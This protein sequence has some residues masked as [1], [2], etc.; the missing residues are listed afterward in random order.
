MI[1][2]SINEIEEAILQSLDRALDAGD[3]GDLPWQTLVEL[4]TFDASMADDG[5][6]FVTSALVAERLGAVLAGLP[7]I[8]HIVA[9]RVLERAGGEAATQRAQ[10]ASEH[11]LVGILAAPEQIA[12]DPEPLSLSG[13]ISAY[14][15]ALNDDGIVL[16]RNVPGESLTNL[17]DLPL[18]AGLT[19]ERIL[20]VSDPVIATEARAERKIL[21]A[22]A[23]AGM[24]LK[25]VELAADYAKERTLFGAPIGG[26]QSLAHGMASGRVHADGMLLLAREAAWARDGDPDR[27]DRLAAMAYGFAAPAAGEATRFA[28]HVFGGYGVTLEYPVQAYFRI[29]KALALAIGDPALD[30][31]RIGQFV[32][33]Q[34]AA[35]SPVRVEI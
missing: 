13:A 11:A 30:L 34:G 21:V 8:D 4:V 3:A 23:L 17:G 32:A 12:G 15:V 33:G 27:F 29:A 20:A 9:M 5:V 16:H 19:G 2:L 14:L 22:A 10:L 25:A 24:A 31:R 26:F 35:P 18:A 1:D 6:T 28:M 7:L